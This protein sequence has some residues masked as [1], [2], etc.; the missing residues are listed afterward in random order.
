MQC[1]VNLI[2]VG[3]YDRILRGQN[4]YIQAIA[5]DGKRYSRMIDD[6]AFMFV[7]Q[8][9]NIVVRGFEE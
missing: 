9:R 3:T 7:T 4:W 5:F 2:Q 1:H 8:I 6:G